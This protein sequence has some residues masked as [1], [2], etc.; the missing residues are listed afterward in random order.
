VTNGTIRRRAAINGVVAGLVAL[1][2]GSAV[3]VAAPGGDLPVPTDTPTDGPSPTPPPCTP[4]WQVVQAADPG[5]TS[6]ALHGIVALAP[7]DAWSVGGSGNP[8]E[9]VQVLIERWDGSAWTA[10]QGPSPGS[11]TNEL[12]A[13]DASGPS[14]VW[15]VG[16]QASGFGDRPLA[17]RFD[18]V[19]W[20]EE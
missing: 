13:V 9:P 17:M 6:N 16:R 18:G 5:D 1:V 14:D 15:A 3:V 8:A 10:E 11:Q 2:I 20:Q 7:T 12:L 4:T 19:Q